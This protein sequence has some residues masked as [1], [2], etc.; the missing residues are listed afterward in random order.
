MFTKR[1]CYLNEGDEKEFEWTANELKDC[2]RNINED[3]DALEETVA[4]VRQNPAKFKVCRSRTL[5]LLL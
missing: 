1:R 5:S 3:A 4:I 2:V